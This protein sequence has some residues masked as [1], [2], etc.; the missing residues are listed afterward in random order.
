[1]RAR[2]TRPGIFTVVREYYTDIIFYEYIEVKVD[3]NNIR[4][5]SRGHYQTIPV[6]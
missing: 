3:V 2:R 1:M 4:A 6:S 5:G